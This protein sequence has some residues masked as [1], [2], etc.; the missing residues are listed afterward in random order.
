MPIYGL[1]ETFPIKMPDGSEWIGG[2]FRTARRTGRRIVVW[3]EA[4]VELF[5]TG[6]QYDLGNATNALDLWLVEQEKMT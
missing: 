1:I 4:G 5:D 3:S 6:D 2:L